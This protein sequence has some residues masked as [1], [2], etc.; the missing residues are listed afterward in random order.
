MKRRYVVCFDALD[1]DQ[2]KAITNAL[3]EN[4]LG[5]WHW[6]D[7]VWFIAD[8][9]GKFNAVEIRELLKVFA[10]EERMIVLELNKERDTWAGIRANDPDKKMFKWF[11]ETWNKNK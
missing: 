7:N 6:I 10:P 9:Q 5:W 8:S 3:S 11:N 1:N 2:S 4:K